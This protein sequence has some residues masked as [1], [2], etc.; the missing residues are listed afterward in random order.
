MLRILVSNDDGVHAPGIHALA[1]A[2]GKIGQVTVV[3]PLQEKSTTGHSLTL[4]K[5]LRIIPVSKNVYGVS[6]SPADCIYLA[7][8]EILKHKPDWVVSGIN[9]GANLGQDVYYSGTV[10][11]AREAAIF[12]IRSMAVSLVLNGGGTHAEGPRERAHFDT[13]GRLATRII[14]AFGEQPL[15]EHTVLNL[16]VPNRPLSKIRGIR[17]AEQGFRHYDG[18]TLKRVDH[19]GKPYYWIGGKYRG[20]RD[21]PGTDCSWVDLGYAA[22]T[23]LNLDS[24]HSEFLKQLKKR[25]AKWG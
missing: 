24:T 7:M 8:G 21:E 19:R 17:G 4:H 13:A 15:P 18:K 10:S 11:A 6:G 2:L 25:E 3:A 1:R 23:P 14:Q 5:P 9:N 20:F 22:I 12:G 16:N